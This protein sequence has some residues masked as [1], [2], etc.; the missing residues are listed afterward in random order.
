VIRVKICGV[1]DAATLE[2]AAQAGAAYVGF[3][4]FPR[5]PRHLAWDEAA[6]LA[7]AA[8]PGLCKVGLAVDPDDAA[9]ERLAALPLDMVQLHGGESPERVGE[10][11][12]RLGLPVMKAVGVAGPEDLDGLDRYEGVADQILCDAKP[13]PGADLPGGTGL[14]FD[15]RLLSGRRW[16]RPWML[17]GGLTPATVGEAIRRTGATQVDVSSGVE[18]AP[19]EKDPARV[20]AFIRAAKAASSRPGAPAVSVPPRRGMR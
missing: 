10:V 11:R 13:A 6:A 5:S 16:S 15:W 4:F 3:V 14:A 12:G 17:A 7:A 18:R 8:P 9:L 20:A 1:R 19:G 2:A